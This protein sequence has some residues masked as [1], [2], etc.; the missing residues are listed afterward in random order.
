MDTGQL[1][2]RLSAAL[3][4]TTPPVALSFVD[5][6]PVDIPTTQEMSPA[7]C[8]FWRRAE[9]T[10]FYAPA[11]AHHNCPIGHMVMGFQMPD[12]IAAEL[13]ELVTNMCECDYIDADEAAKIPSRTGQHVGIVYGPLAQ[14]PNEPTVVLVWLTAQQAML[15][16]EA[17]GSAKWSAETVPRT[18]GRPACAALPLSV[19]N[20]T[21]VMSFGCTGMRT[22]TE[23]DDDRML[24]AIPATQLAAFVVAAEASAATNR[25]MAAFYQDRKATLTANVTA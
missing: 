8:A 25:T 2:Q 16:N 22:F 19:A 12:H 21:P 6:A 11:E 23:I 17:N 18:T 14:H 10:T 20:D 4:L 5:T 13:G 1:A 9:N 24:L 15:C 3:T 7:A